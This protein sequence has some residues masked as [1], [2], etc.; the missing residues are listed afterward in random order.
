MADVLSYDDLL[1][2]FRKL[3]KRADQRL[4]R[5][6]Q[7]G[8]TNVGAYRGAMRRVSQFSP[9]GKRFNVK[10]P[11]DVRAVRARISAVREFLA[12]ET[13]T[14]KGRKAVSKRIRDTIRDKYGLDIKNDDQL[15]AV[16]EGGLWSAL[17]ARFGSD[18]A[19]QI[20]ATVQQSDQDVKDA[21][22]DAS[23]RYFVS[24]RGAED[25]E[26][27]IGQFMSDSNISKVFG[28]NK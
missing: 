16:F 18:T 9:G 3:A 10:V 7:A 15:T 12:A 5:M 6:E 20:L 25:A 21:I 27:I 2:E 17:N 11:K 13:S 28:S 4:V 22:L 24:E 26:E 19:I 1:K 14:A 23:D 8:K